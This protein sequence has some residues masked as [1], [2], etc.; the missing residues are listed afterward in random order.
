MSLNDDFVVAAAAATPPILPEA[1]IR[2]ILQ[3]LARIQYAFL[4]ISFAK[5]PRASHKCQ[6]Q[7]YQ[8][9][10]HGDY[11]YFIIIHLLFITCKDVI[12]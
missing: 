4:T 6:R 10:S 8:G 5:E 1:F 2:K 12:I 11:R 9:E 3:V 7:C